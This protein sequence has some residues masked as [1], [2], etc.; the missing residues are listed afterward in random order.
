VSHLQPGAVAYG[1]HLAVGWWC[2]CILQSYSHHT[3]Q[4]YL[5]GVRTSNAFIAIL[6]T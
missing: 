2:V 1:T 4:D 3:Q 5:N 6:H